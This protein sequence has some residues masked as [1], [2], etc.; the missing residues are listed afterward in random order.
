MR[1]KQPYDNEEKCKKTT[2]IL[3]YK[4]IFAEKLLRNCKKN[5]W[6]KEQLNNL[7]KKVEKLLIT[8]L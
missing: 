7:S 6:K 3:F 1:L 4:V 5:N 2:K 8:V